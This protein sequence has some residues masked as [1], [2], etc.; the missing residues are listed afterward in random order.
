M[1]QSRSAIMMMI[2]RISSA[3]DSNSLRKFSLSTAACLAYKLFDLMRPRMSWAMSSP[4][5][6]FTVSIVRNSLTTKLKSRTEISILRSNPTLSH[7]MSA[8]F[9]LRT[10]GFIPCLFR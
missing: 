10:T 2:T 1:T 8:V 9:R 6:F 4:N 7:K 3:N 5:S